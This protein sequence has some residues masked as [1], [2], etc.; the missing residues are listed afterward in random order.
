MWGVAGFRLKLS[1]TQIY[2]FS[3]RDM[4]C[5]L[6][7][8]VLSSFFGSGQ[9]RI[10]YFTT[11]CFIML[12]LEIDNYIYFLFFLTVA[13]VS[14]ERPDFL[15]ILDLKSNFCAYYLIYFF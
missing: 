11:D 4:L 3:C 5:A 9:N 12:Q 15:G 13:V 14:K 10:F 2:V 8:L 6:S 7:G 1:I